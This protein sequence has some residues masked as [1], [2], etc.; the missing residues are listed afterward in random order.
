MSKRENDKFLG[1]GVHDA[2]SR[3]SGIAIQ[4]VEYMNGNIQVA[5]QPSQKEGETDYPD[6]MQIDYHTVVIDDPGLSSMVTDAPEIHIKLGQRVRDRATGLEG[7]ATKTAT[8]M[9][10][11]V[12]VAVQPKKRKEELFAGNPEE[13]W[14]DFNRLV[15]VDDGLL[16]E[17]IPPSAAPN[18]KVPGGPAVRVNNRHVG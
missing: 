14:I 11:C 1:K 7:I 18:G 16:P 9:N 3:F 2:I 13:S 8:Y 17:T 12:S 10:G 15:V 5:I 4:V 6:A